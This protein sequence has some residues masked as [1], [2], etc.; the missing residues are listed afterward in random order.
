MKL[1]QEECAVMLIL[2]TP[3]VLGVERD[4][5]FR[6]CTRLALRTR[7]QCPQALEDTHSPTLV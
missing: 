3:Q 7:P 6:G 2:L 5:V 1:P 4:S